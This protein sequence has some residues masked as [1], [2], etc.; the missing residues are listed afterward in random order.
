MGFIRTVNNH[1]IVACGVGSTFNLFLLKLKVFYKLWKM[2][3]HKIALNLSVN[4]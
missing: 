2:F 1:W 4:F 3:R